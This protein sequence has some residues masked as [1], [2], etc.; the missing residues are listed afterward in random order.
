[1]SA[2]RTEL[3][4]SGPP[5]DGVVVTYTVREILERIDSQ[6]RTLDARMEALERWRTQVLAF[7]MGSGLLVGGGV[8]SALATVLGG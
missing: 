2:E 3:R 7:A 8:G 5:T 6:L 1:M 4:A